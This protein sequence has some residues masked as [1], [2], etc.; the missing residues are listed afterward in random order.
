MKLRD[1][2]GQPRGFVAIWND[3]PRE[4]TEDFRNWH[5]SEHIPERLSIPGFVSGARYDNEQATP[6]FFT[7]YELTDP[8]IASSR[9]YMTRLNAPTD[10]TRRVTSTFT[11]NW[12]CVGAFTHGDGT[13]AHDAL[14]VARLDVP[15]DV[16]RLADRLSRVG[17]TIGAWRIGQSSREVSALKTTERGKRHV[18]EP[19]ALALVTASDAEELNDIAPIVEETAQ[20]A[21]ASESPGA[22]A[23]YHCA[24]RQKADQSGG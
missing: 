7:L 6:R 17:P 18:G 14:L 5:A 9:P 2:H 19:A 24:I 23:F 10:W 22:I 4:M 8:D 20:A 16:S 11:D 1:M 21:S 12:R 15:V 3:V 13:L